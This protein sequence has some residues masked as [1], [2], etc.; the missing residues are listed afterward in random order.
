VINAMTKR[1]LGSPSIFTYE[2]EA[3][4]KP[5]SYIAID[6]LLFDKGMKKAI[7][8]HCKGKG[9][10][11]RSVEKGFDLY[12][13]DSVL[14]A[15]NNRIPLPPVVLK[16]NADGFYVVKDGRHRSTLSL[17]LGYTHIPAIFPTP[18][19]KKS[20]PKAAGPRAVRQK[21]VF[22]LAK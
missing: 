9:S 20:P 12:K 13:W 11:L 1:K 17:C 4:D 16:Q 22:N 19:L 2:L 10:Q 15:F 3:T 8:D 18:S 6:Q 21:I 14:D 7:A 5:I